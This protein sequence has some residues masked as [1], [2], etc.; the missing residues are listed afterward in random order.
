MRQV[1][2]V[3]LGL[4]CGAWLGNLSGCQ[5]E[6]SSTLNAGTFALDE[7]YSGYSDEFKA[8]NYRLVVSS[9]FSVVTET[10]RIGGRS[11]VMQYSVA[12]RV[13]R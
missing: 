1:I 10:F 7:S 13:R 8:D 6:E 12:S 11:Y 2:M 3:V 9:D 5:C 4:C